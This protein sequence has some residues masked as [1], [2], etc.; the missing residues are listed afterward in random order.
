MTISQVRCRSTTRA[1]R[2]ASEGFLPPSLARRA[3]RLAADS[4]DDHLASAPLQGKSSLPTP[5]LWR[6]RRWTTVD[7]LERHWMSV[8]RVCQLLSRAAMSS[9][10]AKVLTVTELVA[11]S[12]TSFG[13]RRLDAAFFLCAAREL[14]CLCFPSAGSS[15]GERKKAASSRRSPKRSPLLIPRP[16]IP[17]GQQKLSLDILSAHRILCTNVY[18][19]PSG[20]QDHLT[21][22]KR[23]RD[24]GLIRS[25]W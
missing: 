20:P 22:A 12:G 23:P 25:D 7:V 17:D 24:C 15:Q 3:A 10:F 1:A 18:H 2:R 16:L 21:W 6:T 4:R 13:L 5:N 8:W 19:D 11:R 14:R 9:I